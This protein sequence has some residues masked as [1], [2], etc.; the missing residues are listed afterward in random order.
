[1]KMAF[2]QFLELN[3][4]V[5]AIFVGVRRTDPYCEDLSGLDPTDN[6]W[7]SFV[8]IHPIL[9]WRYSDIW[10]YLRTRNVPYCRLYDLGWTSIGDR[11]RTT[12]NPSLKNGNEFKPAY[13]LEDESQ[14]RAGRL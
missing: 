5:K 13:C 7:P 4:Q 11:D 14:E 10:D 2:A 6:G 1:M 3:P 12:P 8:R 9:D